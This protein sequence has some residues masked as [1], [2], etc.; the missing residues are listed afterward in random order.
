M[1]LMSR[2]RVLASGSNMEVQHTANQPEHA[3]K[4]RRPLDG[5]YKLCAEAYLRLL[6]GVR[7]DAELRADVNRWQPY[8]RS[9]GSAKEVRDAIVAQNSAAVVT[10]TIHAAKGGQWDHVD[11]YKR[12][13]LW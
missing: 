8:C 13:G 1:P 2:L 12:Q 11:V 10:S 9:Y 5:R 7:R 6:G 4:M 3:D